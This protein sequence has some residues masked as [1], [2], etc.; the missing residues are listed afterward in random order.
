MKKLCL[1]GAF[2]LSIFTASSAYSACGAGGCGFSAP[3]FGDNCC[4]EPCAPCAQATGNCICQYVRYQPCPYTI[5]RCVQEQCP[6]TVRCCRMI[7]QYYQVQ[8]CRMVPEYYNVTCC[9]QV[10]EYYDVQKCRT[11]CRTVCEQACTYKPV[12]FWKNECNQCPVQQPCAPA[13]S[14]CPCGQ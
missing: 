14:S 8:R 3:S 7:P 11:V 5:K 2:V 13:C 4:A 10:P 9:R 1:L 12:Y 6:Y